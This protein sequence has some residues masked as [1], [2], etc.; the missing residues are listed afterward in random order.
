MT[1]TVHLVRHGQT[2][3]N[4]RGLVQGWVDSPLT[5][6]GVEQARTVGLALASRPLVGVYA[7]TSER[8]EDT[9]N[10][11]A[12]HHRDLGVTRF[13]GLKE[14]YF[15]ELEAR[16]DEELQAGLDIGAFYADMF[17]G[18]GPGLPGGESAEAYT[19]RVS[20]AF[21]SIVAG[22]PDG[23]EVAVVSHGI[24]INMILVASGW[25]SP[26]PLANASISI[27]RIPADGP[28]EVLAVGIPRIPDGLLWH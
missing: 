4:V 15:G 21:T 5:E 10:A 1:L 9:A 23:G 25:T 6:I 14:L 3:F 8:A 19:R 20:S 26:G 11:I 27:L 16:T 2:M 17:A 24:T 12:D 7:S 22:H 18:R 13:K 28:R